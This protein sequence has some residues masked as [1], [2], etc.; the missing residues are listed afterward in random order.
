[1]TSAS[2]HDSTGTNGA[3]SDSTLWT[4]GDWIPNLCGALKGA[5]QE[6]APRDFAHALTVRHPFSSRW[7]KAV[8]RRGDVPL[9]LLA[10]QGGEFLGGGRSTEFLTRL[11]QALDLRKK[12]RRGAVREQVEDWTALVR[13]WTGPANGDMGEADLLAS[14]AALVVAGPL[15]PTRCFLPLWQRIAAAS[16][17]YSSHDLSGELSAAQFIRQVEI[18]WWIANV[19]WPFQFAE[20]LTEG[21]SVRID[22]SIALILGPDGTVDASQIPDLPAWIGSLLRCV[23]LDLDR[24]SQVLAVRTR[25]RL[26]DLVVRATALLDSTGRLPW[27]NPEGSSSPAPDPGILPLLQT[28]AR[29]VGL[30]KNTVARRRLD[31]LESGGEQR[32]PQKVSSDRDKRAKERL[33]SRKARGFQS[34]WGKTACLISDHLPASA[35]VLVRHQASVPELHVEIDGVPLFEGAWRGDVTIDGE[36]L[37]NGSWECSCWYSE[38][39]ADFIELNSHPRSGCLLSRQVVLAKKQGWLLLVDE[40]QAPGH[41]IEY[42]AALSAVRGWEAM[43]DAATREAALGRAGRRVRVCPLDLPQDKVH[44]ATGTFECRPGGIRLG[45]RASGGL[46]AAT[47]YEWHPDHHD[48]AVDWNALTIAEDGRVMSPDEAVGFRIRIGERQ[49]VVYHSLTRAHI[50][51]SVLGLHTL[52]ETLAGNFSTDGIVQPIVEVEFGK[53][54]VQG[55]T[56]GSP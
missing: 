26:T 13:S 14:L 1:M 32:S 27:S 47:L 7:P 56:P 6:R 19:Y 51:R 34:D 44:P 30:S 52:S 21:L 29:V 31:Q 10:K 53:D 12:D 54:S 16:R 50:G 39:D 22:E 17:D 38:K 20:T 15:L 37:V 5:I 49:I 40:V 4:A 3:T 8:R 23:L 36:S 25:S 24:E 48:S 28:A 18:P 42:S 45:R 11:Q 2:T 43:E 33:P 9:T 46:Y 35:R 55:S 41:N